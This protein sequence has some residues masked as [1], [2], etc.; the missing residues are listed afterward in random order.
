MASQPVRQFGTAAG[1]TFARANQM[2]TSLSSHTHVLG[3]S[4]NQLHHNVKQVETTIRTSTIPALLQAARRE[5]EALRRQA[6]RPA[7]TTAGGTASG[8]PAGGG[9][10]SMLGGA[11]GMLGGLGI[12]MSVGAV[13][14]KTMSLLSE[15]EEIYKAI[16]VAQTRLG[17]VMQNTMNA[18]REEINSVIALTAAQEKLGVVGADV[19]L[20]GAQELATYLSRRE[21]LEKLIPVMNNMLAQQYGLNASQEQA[22][23][24]ASMLGKVM[25]GQTGALSRY[26]YKFDA[27][28][29]KILKYGNEAQRVA[30]L[31]DVVNASV[32]GV[33]QALAQTPEGMLKQQENA[34]EGLQARFGTYVVQAKA[35]FVPL[36]SIAMEFAEKLLPVIEQFIKPLTSGIQTVV[37]WIKQASDKTG[38]WMDYVNIIKNLF[39]NSVV[40]LVQKLWGLIVNVVTKLFDFIS[41][42]EILKDILGVIM[43]VYEKLYE[44]IGYVIDALSWVFDNVVMPIL[45]G[46][47][48]AYRWIKGS[49]LGEMKALQKIE[50]QQL[51]TPGEKKDQ[52][53]NQDL[54]RE[55]AKNTAS[56]NAAAG[57]TES[58]ISGGGQKIVNI[59]VAKFLDNIN[60]SAMTMQEGVAD[61][62][63]MILEMFSR[64]ITQGGR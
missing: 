48:K 60:I 38:G 30:V 13:V 29:E 53:T 63:R 37:A 23:N 10:M 17:A 5:L 40:P 47:E 43:I 3:Q 12:V 22:S 11:K 62:E 28:Q 35:A 20:A 61:I 44:V 2:T 55:I 45:E 51:P 8:G 57:G 56:N 32:G 1:Q 18:R 33:N 34:I 26:G 6:A 41:K 7:G 31:F 58:A 27:A 42:S 50:F 4:Y 36:I 54:Y 14:S 52:Q 15:S 21:S 25:D 9:L 46:I 59:S 19:Q 39:M 24:I 64:V 49:D 16:S